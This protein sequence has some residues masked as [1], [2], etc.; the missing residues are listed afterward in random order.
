MPIWI[1]LLIT[2]IG[3]LLNWLWDRE[4]LTLNQQEKLNR[5][6]NDFR[7]I[8]SRAVFL[9]CERGGW[10]RLTSDEKDKRWWEF[11]K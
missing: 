7:L 6:I 10:P 5:L 2:L 1:G 4:S 11:W 8:E 3:W 9:G